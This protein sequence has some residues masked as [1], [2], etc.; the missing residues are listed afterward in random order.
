MPCQAWKKVDFI[1]LIQ[2]KLKFVIQPDGLDEIQHI[3]QT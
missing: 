2:N 1:A 3:C